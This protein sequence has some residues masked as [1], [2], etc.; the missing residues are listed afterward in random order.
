MELSDGA[1]TAASTPVSTRGGVKPLSATPERPRAAPAFFSMHAAH[2]SPS[3]AAGGGGV[4]DAALSAVAAEAS[5]RSPR[6]ARAA[7]A[8]ALADSVFAQPAGAL[9]GAAP[10][11]ALATPVLASARDR[12][13]RLSAPAATADLGVSGYR[14]RLSHSLP[15]GLDDESGA[16]LPLPPRPT[17]KRR[18]PPRTGCT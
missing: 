3:A 6:V 8:A 17:S 14:M 11:P 15:L 2:R 1:G 5:R 12:Q 18:Q 13:R 16:R 9:E 4:L 10:P 7:D